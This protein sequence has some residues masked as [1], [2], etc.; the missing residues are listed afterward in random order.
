MKSVTRVFIESSMSISEKQP[1]ADRSALSVWE[2]WAGLAVLLV[3]SFTVSA[4]QLDEALALVFE[5]SAVVQS[6]RAELAEIRKQSNFKGRVYVGYA[7]AETYDAAQG[8]NAGIYIEIPLFS[9]KREMEAARARLEL[10]RTEEQLKKAFLADVAKIRELEAARLEAVEMA[11]FYRDRLKYFE[12][13][14]KEGRVESDTLWDDAKAAKKAEH[15]AKQGIVKVD[16]AI[17]EAAR[18]YGGYEWKTLQDLL[19][20]IVK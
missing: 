17:E 11:A 4:S 18:R 3:L 5:Q 2:Q 6:A 7:L 19:V 1:M 20:G 10:S 8:G 13:A 16:A 12:E 9:R 15:D 14:V